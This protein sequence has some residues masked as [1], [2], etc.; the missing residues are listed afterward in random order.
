[1]KAAAVQFELESRPIER[2]ACDLVVAGVFREDR[3]LRGGAARMDWR[4]C[5][6][7]SS[8]LQSG[9]IAGERDEAVLIPATGALRAPRALVLGLGSRGRFPL[10]AAQD[11]MRDATRRCLDLAV[12]RV[13]LAPLGIASDDVPR[14]AAAVV[15]GALEAAREATTPLELILAVPG[16]HHEAVSAA[17]ERA[18]RAVAP[19]PVSFRP[20][21]PAR[22]RVSPKGSSAQL[23]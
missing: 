7:L 19:E 10:S 1:V 3:P 9:R 16:P 22:A 8:L 21:A 13:A 6:L 4:L 20:E 5:G 11:V 17:L 15:G 12:R 18:V 2:I 14:H 23:L